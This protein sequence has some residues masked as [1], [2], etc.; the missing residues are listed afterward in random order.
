MTNEAGLEFTVCGKPLSELRGLIAPTEYAK[1]KI[2]NLQEELL[3]WT[4]ALEVLNKVNSDDN[5]RKCCGGWQPIET[6]PKLGQLLLAAKNRLGG[7]EVAN[8]HW[9]KLDAKWVYDCH[10]GPTS[11]PEYWMPLPAPPVKKP[12][13]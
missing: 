13:D 11:Q 3:Q 7:Y 1:R 9:Y 10:F 12:T 4:H 5:R 2:A 6:A 8:G